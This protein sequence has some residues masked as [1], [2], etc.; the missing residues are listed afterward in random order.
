MSADEE[1][2]KKIRIKPTLS[3]FKHNKSSPHIIRE[4]SI[5]GKR[6][7]MRCLPN[8]F[9]IILLPNFGAGVP[10]QFFS[11]KSLLDLDITIAPFWMM[12]RWPKEKVWSSLV[13]QWKR[14]CLA[15]QE[16]GSIPNPVILHAVEWLSLCTT[17]TDPV[18]WESGSH[19]YWNP[20]HTRALLHNKRSLCNEQPTHHS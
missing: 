3:W 1:K 2:Q 5:S 6:L 13:A 12:N 20:S 8:A 15:M 19:S 9:F 14:I 17:T 18:L 10:T 4:S 11:R 16:T 7:S